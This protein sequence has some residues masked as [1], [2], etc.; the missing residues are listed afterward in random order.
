MTSEV[1]YNVYDTMILLKFFSLITIE[2]KKEIMSLDIKDERPLGKHQ[3]IICVLK[4][5]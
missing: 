3:S 2:N 4:R 5:Q 1:F